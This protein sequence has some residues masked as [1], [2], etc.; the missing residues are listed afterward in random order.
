MRILYRTHT[1]EFHGQLQFI[2]QYLQGVSG[3][4][5]TSH[6]RAEQNRSSHRHSLRAQRARLQDIH[7]S[8]NTRVNDHIH[9]ACEFFR[10]G[11]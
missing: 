8:A 1:A 2:N 7:A 6:G 9:L 5:F 10:N 4:C 11:G 3:T